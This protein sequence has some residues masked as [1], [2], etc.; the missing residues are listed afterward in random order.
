MSQDPSGIRLDYQPY[1]AEDED[2]NEED[3][4]LP[5]DSDDQRLSS[6]SHEEKPTLIRPP[7]AAEDGASSAAEDAVA[8]RP[9]FSERV[10]LDDSVFACVGDSPPDDDS[11]KNRSAASSPS[12]TKPLGFGPGFKDQTR[13]NCVEATA[14]PANS[15]LLGPTF[16]DQ[17]RS[18]DP[19]RDDTAVALRASTPPRLK[20]I[21]ESDH[22]SEQE[23]SSLS[24]IVGGNG[25][26]V[27]V[28]VHYLASDGD[29]PQFNATDDNVYDADAFALTGGY[30]VNNRCII[31][32]VA[33]VVL[34]ATVV[35]GVCGSGLCS[36]RTTATIPTA[37]PTTLAP[38]LIPS[39]MPTVDDASKVMVSFINEVTLSGKLLNY[40]VTSDV[41]SATPEER[42][43][44]W[45]ILEDPLQLSATDESDKVQL[46]QRYALLTLW[47]SLTGDDWVI[48]DDWLTNDDEC[49]WYGIACT[50]NRV[51]ALGATKIWRRNNM[52]GTIPADIALL[53]LITQIDLSE[54]QK[55]IGSLPST[56]ANLTLLQ[57]FYSTFCGLRS[58]LSTMKTA[59]HLLPQSHCFSSFIISLTAD[60]SLNPLVQVGVK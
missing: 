3:H 19:P 36:T 55:I 15:S 4:V 29:E 38:T 2:D 5:K 21:R 9:F 6:S 40:P 7:S 50:K 57:S 32:I 44:S 20:S 47:F 52:V 53:S 54:N 27:I 60:H 23:A 10:H 43:L 51:T 25:E 16:K 17:V 59:L 39:S 31:A 18:E 24:Q 26:P 12:S 8:T 33:L 1:V 11:T 30:F 22:F 56:I 28:D 14:H 41:E 58:V 49:S 35:G 46:I 48:K 45:L 34:A 37:A 13:S 42:A